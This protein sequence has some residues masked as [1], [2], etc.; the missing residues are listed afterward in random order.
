[1]KRLLIDFA[2]K[3]KHERFYNLIISDSLIAVLVKKKDEQKAEILYGQNWF[4]DLL[5]I[6]IV[7]SD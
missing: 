4:Q 3:R 5:T 2:C 7:V 6:K 1:M